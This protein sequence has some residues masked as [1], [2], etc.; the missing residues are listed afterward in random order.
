MNREP[1]N[2]F[3]TQVNK[4][5]SILCIVLEAQLFA[6]QFNSEHLPHTMPQT[7]FS[8]PAEEEEQIQ[9]TANTHLIFSERRIA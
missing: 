1:R 6:K 2:L 7:K 9:E 8:D 3:Y 5:E 4:G